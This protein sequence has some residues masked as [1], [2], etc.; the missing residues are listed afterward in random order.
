MSSG[1]PRA[2]AVLLVED[3]PAD[4]RLLIEA[5]KPAIA[6]GAIVIQTVKTLVLAME[7]LQGFDFSCVLLDLGLPDGRGI[8][9][10]RALRE[11]ERKAAIIVLTGLDDEKLAAEALSLGAQDYLVKGSSDGEQLLRQLRRAVQR[12]QQTYRL[13]QRHDRAFF[14]ASHD[15]LTLLPNAALF[16]DRACQRLIALRQLATDPNL[17][18]AP[19]LSFAYLDIKGLDAVRARY[20]SL[21]A[22]ELLRSVAEHWSESLDPQDTLARIGDDS[23]ALLRP[24]TQPADCEALLQHFQRHLS[25]ATTTGMID[26][27]LRLAAGVVST[28]DTL[29]SMEALMATAQQ[30]ADQAGAPK[31]APTTSNAPAISLTAAMD[32]QWQPW[33]DVSSRRCAGL[34][35]ISLNTPL[36]G[37]SNEAIAAHTLA[38]AAALTRQAQQWAVTGF[39]PTRLALNVPAAALTVEGFA[40]GLIS[41][42]ALAELAP[43]RLQ[44]EISESAF[45]HRP[46]H[47]AALMQLHKQGFRLVLE[48]D[49]SLDIPFYDFAAAPVDGYKLGPALVRLLTDEMLHG[50]S[51]R[52]VNAILGAAQHL[53]ATVIARGV[54]SEASIATLRVIGVRWMQGRALLPPQDAANVPPVW[55]RLVVLRV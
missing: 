8:D 46:Q 20:G 37:Q 23:F 35:L 26:Q 4:G 7:A 42:L 31:T 11:V 36:T 34:E 28:Q 41:Q 6:S 55:D 13:E 32:V 39:M 21:R 38:A 14:E 29:Q 15:A 48:A 22:D 49:G 25:T 19:T 53:G 9:G 24:T 33:I 5:L 45:A 47:T 12:H 10:V 1:V 3:S 44:L 17:S 27:A 16:A 30:M 43:E 40:A 51:R 18:S 50:A 52:V 54:D 2:L